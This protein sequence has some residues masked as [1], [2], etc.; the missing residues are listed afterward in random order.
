MSLC[1][2]AI[3]RKKCECDIHTTQNRKRVILKGN[4]AFSVDAL[5]FLMYR[6]FTLQRLFTV[7]CTHADACR[8]YSL[9]IY[10]FYS[11]FTS[12]W[13]TWLHSYSVN[14]QVYSKQGERER[15][16]EQFEFIS[17]REMCSSWWGR[18]SLDLS[19]HFKFWTHHEIS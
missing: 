5:H 2:I 9:N 1:T 18:N 3:R 6:I 4:S 7:H 17:T 16:T 11:E 12:N 19:S 15:Q 8:S 13:I 10:L 14:I